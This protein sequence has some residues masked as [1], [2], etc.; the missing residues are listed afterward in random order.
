MF[1][2]ILGPHSTFVRPVNVYARAKLSYIMLVPYF[3]FPSIFHADLWMNGVVA[4]AE[5]PWQKKICAICGATGDPGNFSRLLLSSLQEIVH[6]HECAR[7][8]LPRH[9]RAPK[10]QKRLQHWVRG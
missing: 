4:Q 1:S 2:P 3:A 10:M 6:H 8:A 7:A 5:G 9:S